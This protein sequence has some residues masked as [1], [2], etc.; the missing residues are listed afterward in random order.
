MIVS[1]SDSA[2]PPSSSLQA[3]Q[4]TPSSQDQ[5]Q[6]DPPQPSYAAATDQKRRWLRKQFPSPPPVLRGPTVELEENIMALCHCQIS[7]HRFN[8]ATDMSIIRKLYG[9][10]VVEIRSVV[11]EESLAKLGFE[12]VKDEHRH[13]P[14]LLRDLHG[15]NTDFGPFGK[16]SLLLAEYFDIA[17]RMLTTLSVSVEQEGSGGEMDDQLLS[18]HLVRGKKRKRDVALQGKERRPSSSHE[19]RFQLDQVLIELEDQNEATPEMGTMVTSS[20]SCTATPRSDLPGSSRGTTSERP[21]SP[22]ALTYEVA[23]EG[24]LKKFSAPI[25]HLPAWM[26]SQWRSRSWFLPIIGPASSPALL[27]T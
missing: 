7:D 16:S 2:S 19:D 22:P 4:S 6:S 18:H 14:N 11:T 17:L 25:V 5:S 12:F 10:G 26:I 21:P 15:R 20:P 27:A 1:D 8:D 9:K 3:D 23:S 13:Q 24:G